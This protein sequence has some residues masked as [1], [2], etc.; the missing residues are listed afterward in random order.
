MATHKIFANDTH[1]E[2]LVVGNSFSTTYTYDASSQTLKVYWKRN[3]PVVLENVAEGELI[4]VSCWGGMPKVK[5]AKLPRRKADALAWIMDFPKEVRAHSKEEYAR[6]L[7]KQREEYSW[8]GYSEY[9]REGDGWAITLC[10]RPDCGGVF[11]IACYISEETAEDKDAVKE[12]LK[13][14]SELRWMYYPKA[15]VSKVLREKFGF[16]ESDLEEVDEYIGNRF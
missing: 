2:R 9:T 4:W 16:S 7:E 10:N 14:W 5:R 8:W 6:L 11:H 12:I 13:A 3:L 1:G 15:F